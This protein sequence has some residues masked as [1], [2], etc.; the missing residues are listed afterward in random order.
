HWREAVKFL[1]ARV[2]GVF[3]LCVDG[4]I[5]RASARWRTSTRLHRPPFAGLLPGPMQP[6]PSEV[7]CVAAARLRDSPGMTGINNLRCSHKRSAEP[8]GRQ[9]KGLAPVDSLSS[10]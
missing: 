7:E 5:G 10:A 3:Y 6:A 9:L 8:C 2:V 4:G 1:S